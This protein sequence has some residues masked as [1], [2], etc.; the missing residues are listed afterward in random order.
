MARKNA[1][2]FV[3]GRYG[4]VDERVRAYIDDE[5]SIGDYVLTGGELA[6]LVMMDAI[7]RLVP[8]SAG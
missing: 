6:T 3:C 7:I 5:V 8:E 2:M 4:G 1:L